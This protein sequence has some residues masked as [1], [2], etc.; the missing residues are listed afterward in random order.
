MGIIG[1]IIILAIFVGLIYIQINSAAIKGKLGEKSVAAIL[2]FLPK[3]EYIV[4]NDLMFKRDGFSTQIDHIVISTHGIFVIETKNYKG[5]IFGNFNQ[6]YWTQNI[7][8]N[9]YPLY[10]PVLQNQNHIKFLIN[11]FN[12]IREHQN[13]V[14]PI[15]VFLRTSHLHLT[16]DGDFVLWRDKLLPYICRFRQNVISIEDCRH[17]ATILEAWNIEDKKER[18]QHNKSVMQSANYTNQKI[19]NGI[20]PRCGGHLVSRTGKFGSFY[21]CSNYPKCRYTYK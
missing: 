17:I 4:L 5:W 15:V 16:G 3:S 1:T 19:A 11:K 20:C 2:S 12:E 14:Y 18:K 13:E 21:G 10:N 9:K 6:T 7:W 8:G